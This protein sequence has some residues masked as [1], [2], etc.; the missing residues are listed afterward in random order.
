MIYIAHSLL[1]LLFLQLDDGAVPVEAKMLLLGSGWT[2]SFT[3]VAV[4]AGLSPNNWIRRSIDFE[5]MLNPPAPGLSWPGAL[6]PVLSSLRFKECFPSWYF[7]FVE[8]G[9]DFGD[10][11]Y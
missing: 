9:E 4:R 11:I 6:L 2:G 3:G 10:L 1:L 7:E 8:S 5:Y